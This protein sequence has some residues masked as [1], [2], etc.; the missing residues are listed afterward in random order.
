[1]D[2]D[3]GDESQ[4]QQHP[5][6]GM[7]VSHHQV[8]EQFHLQQIQQLE[9][10]ASME[11][12]LDSLDAEQALGL[13]RML[14]LFNDNPGYQHV[15]YGQLSSIMRL[16]HKICATCGDTKHSTMEH[17]TAEAS[18]QQ[19][20][21]STD[22][23]WLRGLC[24]ADQIRRLNV[25]ESLDTPGEFICSTCEG[26]YS[27]LFARANVGRDC[28][29]CRSRSRVLAEVPDENLGVG[30]LFFRYRVAES[31]SKEDV[32]YCFDCFT[33]FPSMRYRMDQGLRCPVCAI[34]PEVRNDERPSRPS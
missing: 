4:Q 25:R 13:A 26:C 5:A 3:N 2:F 32:L 28:P 12:F 15:V 30:E 24:P 22:F 1:M 16:I 27:T 6:F 23:D 29:R 8:Q 18:A 7:M 33:E 20:L 31:S 34:Q 9:L 14:T 11:R 17:L 19:S 21:P 10:R